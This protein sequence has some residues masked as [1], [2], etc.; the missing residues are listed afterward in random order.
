MPNVSVDGNQL[1]FVEDFVFRIPDS[2]V[3]RF[4]YDYDD[5]AQKITTL[6]KLQKLHTVPQDCNG[7]NF[8]DI[9]SER[10]T[11]KPLLFLW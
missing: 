9:I 10:F 11:Q 4:H 2:D 5:D 1:Q 7:V 8:F 3:I 6:D